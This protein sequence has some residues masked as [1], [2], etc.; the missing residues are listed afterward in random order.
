MKFSINL[1][2]EATT[3]V[4]FFNDKNKL[5]NQ[6][7]KNRQALEETLEKQASLENSFFTIYNE[8]VKTLLLS[9]KKIISTQDFLKLGGKVGKNILSKKGDTVD[10]FL[11]TGLETLKSDT[12]QVLL[13]GILL[14][15]YRFQKLK[16]KVIEIAPKQINI[17]G[18]FATLEKVVKKAEIIANSCNFARDC[19]NMPGNLFYPESFVKEAK[20]ISKEE[21][22][23]KLQI[24]DKKDLKKEKMNCLLGVSQGSDKDPYLVI[25]KYEA[26]PKSKDTIMLVGKG[27]TFDCG[28]I[29]IKP[30]GKMDEMKFDMCGGAAVLGA[31]KA[32][33]QLKPATNIVALIPTSENLINGS[34][35]KPGDILTAYNGKTIEIGNTD[36]E[37]RLILADA[38][39]YGVK[40]FKPSAVI[41]LATLTGA[42]VIALGSHNCGLMSDN[43]HLIHQLIEAGKKT[44]EK[45]WPLPIDEEYKEQIKGVYADLNNVG[46]RDAGTITAGLFLQHFTDGVPWAHLD[47]AGTAW[48]GKQDYHTKGATGFGVRLLTYLVQNWQEIKK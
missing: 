21:K 40:K 20:K 18:N 36:A 1:K 22:I 26:T 42:C 37:G 46:G 35:L 47:I 12:L 8:E 43:E 13:E 5:C 23:I 38:L 32:I 19:A 16:S 11:P 3:R 27:L 6:T 31:M 45:T 34:A 2:S 15:C 4:L 44:C 24:L 30:A 17:R 10:F 14:G 41:D 29:S 25:M 39:A 7:V 33:S 28:G 48:D 9:T